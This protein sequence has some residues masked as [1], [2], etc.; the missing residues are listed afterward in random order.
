MKGL[1][2]GAAFPDQ[3]VAA[4]QAGR[5]AEAE[6]I[7]RFAVE[8]DPRNFDA[9]HMLGG[10]LTERGA[11]SGALHY[12]ERAAVLS[13]R[14]PYLQNNIGVAL[15]ELGRHAEAIR[16]LRLA[17]AAQPTFA[18]A[19]CNLG[20]AEDAMGADLEALE[21]LDRAIALDSTM[22]RA[23]SYRGGVLQRLGRLQEALASFERAL[24]VRPAYAIARIKRAAVLVALGQP[25]DAL[26]SLEAALKAEPTNWLAHVNASAVLESLGRFADMLDVCDRALGIASD[27]AAVHNARGVALNYLGRHADAL[28]SFQRAMKLD[29]R[30]ADAHWNASLCYLRLGRMQQGWPLYEW[31][32]RLPRPLAAAPRAGRAWTGEQSLAGRSLLIVAEQ[33]LGDSIQFCRF[34]T[35]AARRGATVVLEVPPPLRA[36][37]SSVEG[38]TATV[39]ANDSLPHVDFSCSMVSLPLAFCTTLDSIPAHV[40]YLRADAARLEWWR[41]R[42]GPRRRLRVGLTWSG[43]LRSHLPELAATNGRR[44]I[45]LALLGPLRHPEIEFYSLQKGDAAE[46]ELRQ[47][48]A[49]NWNGPEIHDLTAWLSDFADTAA[50]LEQLD[51]IISVDTSTAHLAGALAKPVWILNRFDSCWRWL[52]DRTD[53]PWYPTARL[54]R[55]TSPGDWQGVVERVRADLFALAEFD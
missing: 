19:H 1:R 47:A 28:E 23:H 4:R 22:A 44:N 43:G 3:A 9:L 36:L 53:S 6:R 25:A 48:V 24:Q 31:R 16:A 18:D 35:A 14:N 40:P 54:Y 37:L 11:W 32:K 51:L 34:A 39:G 5:R 10:L 38:V 13:P 20:A 42:L 8:R 27:Q 52:S 21:S 45:P 33:G 30:Y 29:A 46:A 50:L 41:A 49:S 15:N 55:Q 2:D 17:I 7:C 26:A 12:F